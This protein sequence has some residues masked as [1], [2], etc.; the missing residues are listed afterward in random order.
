MTKADLYPRG[1]LAHE[2]QVGDL[3]TVKPPDPEGPVRVC[4]EK[5]PDHS[6]KWGFPGNNKFFSF[7]GYLC[8]VLVI[9]RE[10]TP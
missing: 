8:P 10:D 7:M 1:L 9:G 4:L 3:F 6:I 5:L 2:L